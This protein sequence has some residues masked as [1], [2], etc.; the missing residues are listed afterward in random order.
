MNVYLLGNPL[1]PLDSLPLRLKSRLIARFPK[2]TFLEIDPT[3]N[4]IPENDSA[5]IDIVIGLKKV[6]LFNSIEAFVDSPRVSVHDYDLSLHLKLLKKL[7]KVNRIRIIGLPQG[8]SMKHAL[9]Q[10]EIIIQSFTPSGF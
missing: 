2:I 9:I 8:I 7:G 1:D 5:I 6:H 10:I 3:E 4:F